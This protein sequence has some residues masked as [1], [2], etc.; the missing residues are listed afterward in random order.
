M[1]WRPRRYNTTCI[2]DVLYNNTGT[3][4]FFLSKFRALQIGKQAMVCLMF[5]MLTCVCL[6]ADVRPFTVYTFSVEV[7]TA[8]GCTSSPSASIRTSQ[9]LPAGAR[10]VWPTENTLMIMS[11]DSSDVCSHVRVADSLS[12]CVACVSNTHKVSLPIRHTITKWSHL[13]ETKKN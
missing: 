9:H 11:R 5:V 6:L 7:C 3:F 13:E 8:V 2:I 12:T 10:C 4:L 1:G